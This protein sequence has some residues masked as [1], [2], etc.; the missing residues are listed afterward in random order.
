M[1]DSISVH[2]KIPV[3]NPRGGADMNNTGRFI[4]QK[5]HI[6]YESQTSPHDRRKSSTRFPENL[7]SLKRSQDFSQNTQ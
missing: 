1:L 2:S 6:I 3:T 7:G 4:H 5:L